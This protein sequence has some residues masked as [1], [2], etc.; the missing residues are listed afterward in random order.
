MSFAIS[1][2]ELA[3]VSSLIVCGGIVTGLL[4]GLF[5]IGGGAIIVPV[6]YELF[7]VLDVPEGVRFQLCLGTSFAIILPTTVR[8]YVAHRARGAVLDDVL[9]QWALPSIVGVGLGS[10]IAAVAPAAVFK[11]VFILFVNVI[12][13]KLLFGRENWRLGS[14]LPARMAMIGYGGFLGLV[15][16]LVGVSGGSLSNMVLTL[17]GKPIHN[18]VATGAGFGVPVTLAGVVG[19]VIAGWKFQPELPTF[20]I[21]FVSLIGFALMAPVSAFTAGYG[22]RLAHALPRRKLEVAF[23]VFLLLVSIRFLVSLA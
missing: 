19:Y 4:S 12:A 10:W 3:F 9:R 2:Q 1:L 5:G 7:R 18:A 14:E 6:L 21:G 22:A 23:G 16:A 13:F 17:Y 20:S 11:I 15:A 8:S